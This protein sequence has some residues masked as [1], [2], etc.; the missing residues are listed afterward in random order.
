[1]LHLGPFDLISLSVDHCSSL[2]DSD[3]NLSDVQEIY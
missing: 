3:V 2:L 1:M